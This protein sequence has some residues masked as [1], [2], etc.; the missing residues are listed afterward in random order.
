MADREPANPVGRLSDVN[1]GTLSSADHA[2]HDRWLVVR[3]ASHDT[4]LTPAESASARALLE[5][6]DE[7]ASLAADIT[8]I[9]QA[10]AVSLAPARPRDFRLTPA[11]AATSRGGALD[12]LGRWLASPRASI[13]RPLAGAS[14]AIGIVLVAVGPS[15][16]GPV[17]PPVPGPNAGIAAPAESAAAADVAAPLDTATPDPAHIMDM[18]LAPQGSGPVNPEVQTGLAPDASPGM[19]GVSA[20]AASQPPD[21]T[22]L[23]DATPPPDASSV[24]RMAKSSPGVSP[25]VT[26]EVTP[27]PQVADVQ[28]VAGASPASGGS[29]QDAVAPSSVRSPDDTTKA[30]VLLGIVL[31]GTGILIL[32][33]TW[34]VR[35][36]TRDPLL[37]R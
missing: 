29:G 35:R 20:M 3:A 27:D 24:T 2:Q 9:T 8:T 17:Q 30:I 22:Q 25:D 33:L 34:L 31:A 4:D 26:A 18:Q 5:G 28:G 21:A 16:K 7:C 15:I 23:P 19:A 32:L 10:T 11:Q 37:P 1:P 6:C 14:L 36:M 13:L 12:R